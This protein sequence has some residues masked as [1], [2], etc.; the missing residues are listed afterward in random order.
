MTKHWLCGD[1]G[2]LFFLS[3][4]FILISRVFITDDTLIFMASFFLDRY[5]YKDTGVEI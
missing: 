1:K 5:G 4:Y 3:S 2:I